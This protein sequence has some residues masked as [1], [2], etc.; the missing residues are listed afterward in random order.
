MGRHFPGGI[1]HMP[2]AICHMKYGIWHINSKF[3]LC[4]LRRELLSWLVSSLTG[5]RHLDLVSGNLP[6]EE[7]RNVVSI[8]TD[9]D[10]ERNLV[11]ADLAIGDWIVALHSRHG[12]RQLFSFRLEGEGRFAGLAASSRNL[13]GPF[14]IDIRRPGQRQGGEHETY[15]EKHSSLI[16]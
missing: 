11:S 3:L 15:G 10:R 14:A 16:H 4:P 7:K 6:F 2:Y 13:G 12:S 8:E 1:F 5:A 9:L